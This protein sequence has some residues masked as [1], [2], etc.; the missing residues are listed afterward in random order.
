MVYNLRPRPDEQL[1]IIARTFPQDILHLI[2]LF[3][4]CLPKH[5]YSLRKRNSN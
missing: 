3:H 5:R 4:H 1:E 2:A